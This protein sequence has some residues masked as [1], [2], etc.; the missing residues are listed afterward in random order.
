MADWGFW[1]TK[2]RVFSPGCGF[3]E[4]WKTTAEL[5][6]IYGVIGKWLVHVSG[7]DWGWLVGDWSTFLGVIGGWLGVIGGDWG[8]LVVLADQNGVCFPQVLASVKTEKYCWSEYYI[9]LIVRTDLFLGI[10]TR[11]R[12]I[13]RILQKAL[14]WIVSM[15]VSVVST[16][17]RNNF[18]NI[19]PP[20][21]SIHS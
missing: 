8:W 5:T 15:C 2:R 6:I 9:I 18:F 1:P 10:C 13:L 3:C 12:S 4:H 17:H 21:S 14:L 20:K 16:F 19:P 7:G 11:R